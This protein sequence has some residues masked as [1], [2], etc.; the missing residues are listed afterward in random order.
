MFEYLSNS[1]RSI[2]FIQIDVTKLLEA[3]VHILPFLD[4]GGYDDLCLTAS[5]PFT[6]M[7]YSPYPERKV[8]RNTFGGRIGRIR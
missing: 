1:E 5:L 8:R 4:C 2:G 7:W 3:A 6:A